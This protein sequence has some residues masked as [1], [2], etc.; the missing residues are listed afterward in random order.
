MLKDFFWDDE[1]RAKWDDMLIQSETLEECPTTGT[2][3]VQ[4]VRK[5]GGC[6]PSCE[7]LCSDCVVKMLIVL[8]LLASSFPSFVVTES[9][10]LAVEFGSLEET[11]TV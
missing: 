7:F 3:V 6:F 1:F 8:F 5:V 9:T 11:I 10:S 2:M 4:W